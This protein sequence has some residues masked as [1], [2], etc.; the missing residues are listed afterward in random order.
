MPFT[1][2]EIRQVYELPITELVFR[3]ATVHRRHNDPTVVQKCTL[4][5]IKTGRCPEDCSYCPQSA[6]HDAPVQ[7]HGLKNAA[8]VV[9]AA[10]EAKEA[11][12]SRF[13]LGAAWRGPRDGEDFDNVL[14]MVRGIRDLGME[15]CV[16]LGML[17][18]SQARRLKEAGLT[19]YN[20]N[21]DTSPEYYSKIVKT[22]TY[23]DRLRTIG[24]VQDAGI[25]VCCGGI[26]GMGEERADRIG[27]LHTLANLEPQP[28]SVPINVLVKVKGTPLEQAKD[29]DPIELV[30]CVATARILMPKARVRLS[31]GRMSMTDELQALCFV[32]GANS[33]FAGEKLLT[34][35]NPGDRDDALFEKLGLRVELAEVSLQDHVEATAAAS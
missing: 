1:R 31:A 12:A 9:A 30:R 16:T 6:H 3:A 13:C 27:L 5:S 17:N 35:A 7:A 21:L 2:D 10:R 8:E 34:T 4:N 20:H 25:S 26:I 14:E 23:E 22:R 24:H 19:A 18:E 33:I 15:A 32:A 11:G 28:E 29:I